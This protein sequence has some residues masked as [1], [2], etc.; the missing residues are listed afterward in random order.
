MTCSLLDEYNNKT[1]IGVDN[2]KY[3]LI[4]TMESP[5]PAVVGENTNNFFVPIPINQMTDVLSFTIGQ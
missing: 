4:P 2:G 1:T 3:T 5:L